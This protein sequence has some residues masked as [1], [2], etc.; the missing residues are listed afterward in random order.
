MQFAWWLGG[1][2]IG[3]QVAAPRAR[4]LFAG[5]VWRPMLV[6]KGQVALHASSVGQ[7]PEAGWVYEPHH[8]EGGGIGFRPVRPH[9]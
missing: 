2:M 6:P 5:A 8:V 4:T 3:R 9:W 7:P 1:D